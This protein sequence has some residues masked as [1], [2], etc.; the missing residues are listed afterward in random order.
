MTGQGTSL[1]ATPSQR[2]HMRQKWQKDRGNQRGTRARRTT[3]GPERADRGGSRG[4][5]AE[6]ARGEPG[7]R[8]LAGSQGQRGSR[9]ARANGARGEPG[10]TEPPRGRPHPAEEPASTRACVN[11]NRQ[12]SPTETAACGEPQR[13][14]Q[15]G[16]GTGAS[17]HGQATRATTHGHRQRASNHSRAPTTR[18]K[19]E[20]RQLTRSARGC[21]RASP[22]S[23]TPGTD[24]FREE[25]TRGWQRAGPTGRR[26][27]WGTNARARCARICP[28]TPQGRSPP[29]TH[30]PPT[31]ARPARASARQSPLRART[32][33]PG[34]RLRTRDP[35]PLA[36]EK[37]DELATRG[38]RIL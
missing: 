3:R 37:V 30:P 24:A 4:A 7:P 17:N 16:A 10:P 38:P 8:G 35:G 34:K 21:L 13:G 31:S 20:C 32:T 15:P 28:T 23:S 19:P 18:R 14:R 12:N 36:T 29:T 6:G 5:R 26:S 25:P 33:R 27:A 9:G 2:G 22:T 1:P 11:Q